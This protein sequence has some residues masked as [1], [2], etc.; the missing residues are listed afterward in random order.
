MA[1]V[2][3]IVDILRCGTED[4]SRSGGPGAGLRSCSFGNSGMAMDSEGLKPRW[5]G[6]EEEVGLEGDV[7]LAW[8]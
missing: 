6:R 2:E 8:I 7:D 5:N 3:L 1:D 4:K